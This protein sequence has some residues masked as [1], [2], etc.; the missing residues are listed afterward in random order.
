MTNYTVTA[1]FTVH[2]DS[3]AALQGIAALTG[4]SGG[5]ERSQIEAAVKAGLKEVPG[6]VRRYGFTVSDATATVAP[7]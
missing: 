6:L 1:T 7:A 4:T 3:P 2:A 5:D